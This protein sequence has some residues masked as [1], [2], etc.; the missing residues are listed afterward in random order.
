MKPSASNRVLIKGGKVVNDD[1]SQL[2]DVYIEDG[3][4]QQVGPSLSVPGGARIVDATDKIVIPGGI[5]THTHMQLPFMGQVAID[6]FYTGTRAAVAG[7]TT[8][9]MDFVIPQKGEGLMQAY[10][11][12][13]GWADPKVCIDYSFHVAVTWW[14]EGVKEDMEALVKDKGVNSFKMFMAYKDVFQLNDSQMIEVFKACR[15]IGALAMVHAENGD[16]VAELQKQVKSL[17]ITGPEGHAY[18]RPEEV[19]TEAVNRAIMLSGQQHCPLYVVHVMSKSAADAIIHHRQKGQVVFGEP[20]AAS[21]G[22]DGSHYFNKCW[23]HAAGHVLSPPLRAD[24]STPKY[25]MQ[26]LAS[27]G[28]SCVGTDNCTFSSDQKAMGKDDFTK[29]PNGVNGVEDRMSV[30]W[31]RG[32]VNGILDENKFVA[33]TSSN[34]ARIF[35]CYPKKG[36]IAVGSDA[37]IVVWDPSVKRVISKDTHH[38]AVD[39]NIFEG[40]TVFGAPTFVFSQGVAVLDDG[41]LRV[42]AGSGKFVSCK[43]NCAHVFQ[44]SKHREKTQMPQKVERDAYS[45]SVASG[46]GS[47]T[48]TPTPGKPSSPRYSDDAP[49]SARKAVP[50]GQKDLHASSFQLT[51]EQDDDKAAARP[52]SR[53][54]RAPGGGSSFAFG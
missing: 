4:I 49:S 28:L 34:A 23:R 16:M 9:I 20:I 12:W 47:A 3:V 11:K 42:T 19:E 27:G 39:F 30:V 46:A 26:L 45:G 44:L 29:I 31:T 50:S 32:V 53:V 54:L 22:T 18:S 51:G 41:Q 10:D 40:Q 48:S 2:A 37:D 24:P 14:S 8:M 1:Y 52:S 25:L 36:R 21:L 5:D 38:Q 6:D 7:G 33:V 35:N 17:G 13:R 43:P 15:D